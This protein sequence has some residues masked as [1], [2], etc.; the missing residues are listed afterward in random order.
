MFI[1]EALEI[2]PEYRYKYAKIDVS[3]CAQ[4]V[5]GHLCEQSVSAHIWV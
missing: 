4:V 5:R 2:E 1:R 3:Q